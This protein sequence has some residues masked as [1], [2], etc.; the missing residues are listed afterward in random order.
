VKTQDE[1]DFL[2]YLVIGL[3]HN[4]FALDKPNDQ[5]KNYVGPSPDE[6]AIL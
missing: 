4:C 5:F 6:V 1:L 2:F 3:C